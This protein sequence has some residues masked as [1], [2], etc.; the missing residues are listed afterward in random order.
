GLS[1][2]L[3]EATIDSITGT[4]S[5]G[6]RD[7]AQRAAGL[8]AVLGDADGLFTPG[9]RALLSEFLDRLADAPPTG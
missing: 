2:R 1:R 8:K 7:H 5:S 4:E 9:E 3:R 6:G